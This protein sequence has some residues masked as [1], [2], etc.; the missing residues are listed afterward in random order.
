MESN[1]I[2]IRFFFMSTLLLQ[3]DLHTCQMNM[4]SVKY[5]EHDIFNMRKLHAKMFIGHYCEIQKQ[6]E[7]YAQTANRN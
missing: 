7:R 4:Y 1:L 6:D 5:R 3:C 2:S